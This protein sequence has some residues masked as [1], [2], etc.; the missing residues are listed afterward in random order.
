MT[1]IDYIKYKALALIAIVFIY[2]MVRSFNHARHQASA[3]P[4]EEA[5]QE[6]QE[7]RVPR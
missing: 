3:H 2:S 4:E 7:A 6:H 1:F 5:P